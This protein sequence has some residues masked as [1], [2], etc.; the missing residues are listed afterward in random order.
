MQE[1]EIYEKMK[2]I[3]R[4]VFDDD[5]IPVTP[6]LTAD[7]VAGWDS[8]RNLRLVMTIEKAFHVKLLASDLDEADNVGGLVQLVKRKLDQVKDGAQAQTQLSSRS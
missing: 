1:S 2:E 7:D 5:C 3:F 4:Q 8:I 6:E